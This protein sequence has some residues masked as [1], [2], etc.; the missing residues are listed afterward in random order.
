MTW[1]FDP[2]VVFIF[3]PGL[4]ACG[5]VNTTAQTVASVSKPVFNGYP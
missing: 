5:F 3:T 4:G 2:G 1:L